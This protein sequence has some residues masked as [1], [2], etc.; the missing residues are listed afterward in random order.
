MIEFIINYTMILGV[1]LL[2][3]AVIM[4]PLE[5][6]KKRYNERLSVICAL[7]TA[8]ILIGILATRI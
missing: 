1:A 5:V 4:V 7:V 8:A 2:S 3:T 6:M